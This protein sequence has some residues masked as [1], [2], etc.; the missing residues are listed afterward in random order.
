MNKYTLLYFLEKFPDEQSCRKYLEEVRWNN[1]PI[2]PHCKNTHNIYRYSDGKLFKCSECGKR[3][4]V[5]TGTIYQ[6]S[7]IPLRKW[8]LTSYL[9]ALSKSQL[10]P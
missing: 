6:K 9:M 10:A 2:C 4:Q 7:K 1:N 8:F 3:F 5:T